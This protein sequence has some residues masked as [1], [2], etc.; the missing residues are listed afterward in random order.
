MPAEEPMVG[1]LYAYYYVAVNSS[2]VCISPSSFAL[3]SDM[4]TQFFKSS[5]DVV[6]FDE[7]SC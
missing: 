1:R 2:A 4:H 5:T 7:V 6:L 3:T